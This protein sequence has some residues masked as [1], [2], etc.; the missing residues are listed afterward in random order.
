MFSNRSRTAFAV[1]AAASSVAVAAAPASAAPNI[2][3]RFTRSSEALHLKLQQQYCSALLT[4]YLGYLDLRASDFHNNDFTNVAI[5]D[6]E[7]DRIQQNAKSAGC[8]WA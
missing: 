8:S 6:N 5:D 1:L 7:L 3:N 2:P 4:S